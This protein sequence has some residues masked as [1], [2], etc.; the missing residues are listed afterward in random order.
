MTKHSLLLAATALVLT[1]GVTSGQNQQSQTK[2]DAPTALQSTTP[3]K[4]PVAIVPEAA[5][6]VAGVPRTETT[7]QAPNVSKTMGAEMD[8]AGDQRASPDEQ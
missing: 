5:T 3:D 1:S 4:P 6:D 8:S 7:G 2:T